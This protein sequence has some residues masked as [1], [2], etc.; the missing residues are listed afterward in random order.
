MDMVQSVPY[1]DNYFTHVLMNFGPQLMSD[2]SKALTGKLTTSEF[3][4][5]LLMLCGNQRPIVS[6]AREAVPDSPAGLSRA[7][8]HLSKKLYHLF[9]HHPSCQAHG[10]TLVPLEATSRR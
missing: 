7:G 10:A 1:S 4:F 2:P 9:F 3:F 8:S 6:C 5:E